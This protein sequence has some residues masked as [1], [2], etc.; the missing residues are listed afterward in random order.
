MSPTTLK[1]NKLTFLPSD[2]LVNEVVTIVSNSE[3]V[4]WATHLRIECTNFNF[5]NTVFSLHGVGGPFAAL[6]TIQGSDQ[7][8]LLAIAFLNGRLAIHDV[9]TSTKIWE[10]SDQERLMRQNDQFPLT[11]KALVANENYIVAATEH[12]L[13]VFQ[14]ALSDTS[15]SSWS[16]QLEGR[17]NYVA[18]DGENVL[19]HEHGEPVIT[20]WS[21]GRRM[22]TYDSINSQQ[23]ITAITYDFKFPSSKTGYVEKDFG[24]QKY[25]AAGRAD[26][27]VDIWMWDADANSSLSVQPVRT[28][29]P[30]FKQDEMR[31]T[32][33]A[34]SDILLFAGYLDGSIR[35]FDLLSSQLV[36][37][38]NEQSTPKHAL[39]QVLQGLADDRR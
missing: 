5:K 3:Y 30:A 39:R 34:C 29:L 10:T 7:H 20:R 18:L 27:T 11:V 13:H 12:S 17:L 35:A 21:Q 26:G 38:F 23:P 31:V 24:Q 9:V 14:H 32:A 33:L 8:S 22:K 4:F 1:A 25:V 2:N 19:V 6:A 28:L 36:R 16:V 37:V 15:S